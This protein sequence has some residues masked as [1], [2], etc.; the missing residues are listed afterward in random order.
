MVSSGL[1]GES[2]FWE[3]RKQMLARQSFNDKQKE[4]KS[5]SLVTPR[6]TGES[7]TI[8]YTLTPDLMYS[9]FVQYPAVRAAYEENVPDK[10][11]TTDFWQ[12]YFT[13]EYFYQSRTSNIEKSNKS[14]PFFSKYSEADEQDSQPHL[15]KGKFETTSIAKKLVNLTANEGDVS[16]NFGNKK[17]ITMIPG[18]E[19]ESLKLIRRLNRHS[20]TVVRN[21]I[22]EFLGARPETVLKETLSSSTID[23]ALLKETGLID[24]EFSKKSDDIEIHVDD[25]SQF[26]ISQ[27]EI[28]D[29]KEFEMDDVVSR[30]IN[31]VENWKSDLKQITLDET[32]I[33]NTLSQLNK[34][35]LKQKLIS[36]P[37]TGPNLTPSLSEV[38]ESTYEILRHFWS[39]ITGPNAV[40]N[41][42]KTQRM[43]EA[44]K[45]ITAKIHGALL[46][47]NKE[48]WELMDN[49]L[50]GLKECLDK[51]NDK[52]KEISR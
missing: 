35:S 36:G 13:S 22:D 31:Q 30:F 43:V 47:V 37:I 49:R 18:K 14:D 27:R 20:E 42:T 23:D 29:L 7:S 41:M 5:S 11:S 46:Q 25:V 28:D 15:K 34:E 39:S 24:L 50:W 21:K 1:V 38:T 19:K 48:D 33:Q 40:Q 26:Y 45:K 16:E 51:A 4:G 9:I 6:P 2:E 44:L 32:G 17:D 3:S 10:I 52:W 12:K 8:T